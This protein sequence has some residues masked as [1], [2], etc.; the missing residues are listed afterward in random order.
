M[1]HDQGVLRYPVICRTPSALPGRTPEPLSL[2]GTPALR[3]LAQRADTPTQ[4]SL[5]SRHSGKYRPQ[6]AG[7]NRQKDLDWASRTA[8]EEQM[9]PSVT[10]G[11]A[12]SRHADSTNSPIC[13]AEC[14]AGHVGTGNGVLAVARTRRR[15]T[16]HSREITQGDPST[17]SAMTRRE[18]AGR[19]TAARK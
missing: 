3:G 19:L 1:A 2:P 11:D 7:K 12:T 15:P 6:G 18:G 14:S 13:P 9:T 5:S 17:V 8:T 4:R 16:S 10:R